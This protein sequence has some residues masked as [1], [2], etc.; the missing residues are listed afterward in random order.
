VD[1]KQLADEVDASRSGHRNPYETPKL[2]VFG[3]VGV[4][5]QSGTQGSGESGN[6]GMMKAFP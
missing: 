2:K 6:M 5:T 3:P 1:I 4:L